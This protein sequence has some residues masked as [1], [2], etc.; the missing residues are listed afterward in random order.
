MTALDATVVAITALDK[1]ASRMVYWALLGDET[2]RLW[3][4]LTSLAAILGQHAKNSHRMTS[5][6]GGSAASTAAARFQGSPPEL[7][8]DDLELSLRACGARR[9]RT[10]GL[11]RVVM[12]ADG[13]EELPSL[14]PGFPMRDARVSA[15]AAAGA[16]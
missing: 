6:L 3:L 9:V 13:P 14:A 8:E 16:A 5:L 2:F 15:V 7:T 10:L 12:P 1:P 11:R 4:P